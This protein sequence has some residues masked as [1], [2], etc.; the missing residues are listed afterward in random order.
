MHLIL[1]AYNFI[2]FIAVLKVVDHVSFLA[3]SPISAKHLQAFMIFIDTPARQVPNAIQLCEDY[4]L[5]QRVDVDGVVSYQ[6]HELTSEVRRSQVPITQ[7]AEI[8][9]TLIH[10]FYSRFSALNRITREALHD[11]SL[12][13]QH[14][15]HVCWQWRNAQEG[16][17][18]R[19]NQSLMQDWDLLSYCCYHMAHF[20]A[21]TGMLTM[22]K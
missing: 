21:K 9:A 15:E 5:L 13:Y 12:L 11:L 1:K 14:A 10:F 6:M 4:G 2:L 3:S 16:E 20:K 7:H 19:A 17:L 8:Q 18:D 22:H